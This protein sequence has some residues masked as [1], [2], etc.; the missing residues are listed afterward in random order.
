MLA[1]LLM[2]QSVY[3]IGLIIFISLLIATEVGQQFGRRLAK[4][5][6]VPEK[7]ER[8]PATISTAIMGLL[9]F[10]LAISLSMADGR[11]DTRR[12]LILEEANAIGTAHL[13]AQT[14]GGRHGEEIMRLLVDYTQLRLDF[15]AA[16]EDQKRLR[17]VHEQSAI[18]QRQI[19]ENASAIAALAPTPVSSIL[20][21][22]LNQVI[23]LSTAQRWAFEVRVPT[24][25]IKTLVLISLLAMGILGYYFSL[26]GFRHFVLS[27]LLCLA[28]TAAIALIIDLDKPRSG[29]IQPEQSPLIWT[30]ESI[31]GSGPISRPIR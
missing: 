9:A 2:N 13:R 3:L 10:M 28:L 23:D 5:G 29:Y 6:S 27:S 24:H 16:G 22:S 4:G 30:L 19:W 15:F 17:T 1:D 21:Q 18:V 20:L 12:K 7:R 26:S 8:G 14:I 31:K 25:V 11:F